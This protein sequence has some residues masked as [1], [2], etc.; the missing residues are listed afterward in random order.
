MIQRCYT[1]CLISDAD[2]PTLDTLFNTYLI[3][4]GFVSDNMPVEEIGQER[5]FGRSVI[6]F[7]RFLRRMDPPFIEL[8]PRTL[9]RRYTKNRRFRRR[10]Q[11]TFEELSDVDSENMPID[12]VGLVS[13]PRSSI[14]GVLGS[15]RSEMFGYFQHF[16]RTLLARE[17]ETNLDRSTMGFE[18]FGFFHIR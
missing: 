18:I 12:I 9:E 8:P 10:L 13:A 2:F 15:E 16:E 6:N 3:Q 1:F 14:V 7:S 17:Y 5:E 4:R 11:I